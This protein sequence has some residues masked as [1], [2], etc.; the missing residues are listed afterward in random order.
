MI[1]GAALLLSLVVLVIS[2]ETACTDLYPRNCRRWAKKGYCSVLKH[3]PALQTKCRRSCNF[4]E[5]STCFDLAGTSSCE[6][7]LHLGLC[8]EGKVT[9]MCALTCGRCSSRDPAKCPSLSI[10]HGYFL[11]R[12]NL[13]KNNLKVEINGITTAGSVVKIGCDDGY[14]L[15]GNDKVR[16]LSNGVYDGKLGVCIRKNECEVPTYGIT[17]NRI[18]RYFLV[19]EA[20]SLNSNVVSPGTYAILVCQNGRKQKSFCSSFGTW[21][22]PLKDCDDDTAEWSRW[23]EDNTINARHIGG[24]A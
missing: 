7:W 10:E 6:E 8:A 16:C 14:Q 12:G 15:M 21:L 4:C 11:S 9:E 2:E 18:D 20:M 17:Y 23:Y 13:K 5:E 3:R 19:S 22:P 1:Q 24:A